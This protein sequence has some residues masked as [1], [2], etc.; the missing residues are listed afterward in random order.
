MFSTNLL[1]SEKTNTNDHTHTQTDTHVN[2]AQHPPSHL[3]VDLNDIDLLLV[4]PLTRTLQTAT[5]VFQ[6]EEDILPVHIPKISHP[7]LAERVGAL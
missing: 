5:Y 1:S 6:L 2:T 3:G 4:S 7:L